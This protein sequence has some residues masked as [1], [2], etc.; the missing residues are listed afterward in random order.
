MMP[1]MIRTRFL[2]RQS[3]SFYIKHN[4]VHDLFADLKGSF[5]DH[6]HFLLNGFRARTDVRYHATLFKVRNVNLLL[7]RN[8][9]PFIFVL[10]RQD[11][12]KLGS[13]V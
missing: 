5:A 12:L 13:A 8:S 10:F 9:I 7:R 6:N 11:F 2:L 1:A 4:S 3:D